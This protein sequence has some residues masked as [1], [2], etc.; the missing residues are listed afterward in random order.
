[1]KTATKPALE[2]LLVRSRASAFIRSRLRT[3]LALITPVLLGIGPCGPIPGTELDGNL[4]QELI[5]DFRFVDKVE[6]CQLQ[7]MPSD[8]HSVTVNCWS[9]GKQLYVGC[10]DCEGKTWSSALKQ[11]PVAKIKIGEDIYRVKASR[12]SDKGAIERAWKIRWS[13]YEQGTT[14]DPVPEGYWL[15]HLGSRPTG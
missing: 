11:D 2:P 8:P 13:K 6:H 5:K 15:F 10:M 3:L 1:M 4:K 7:V 12:L 14:P 9:V